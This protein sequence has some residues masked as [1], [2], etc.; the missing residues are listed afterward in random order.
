MK[1]EYAHSL[2]QADARNRLQALGE[3]LTNRHK[4]AVT[5]NGDRATFQGRFKRIVKIRGELSV[6][7]GVVLFSGE[8]PGI[9]WRGQ[10]TKYIKKKLAAYLDPATPAEELKRA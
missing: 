3:Y 9:A 6:A 2:E 1:L 10:A 5:W 8:D 4:I 7:D